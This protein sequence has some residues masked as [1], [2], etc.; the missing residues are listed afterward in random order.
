MELT[1]GEISYVARL[2]DLDTKRRGRPC[3]RLGYDTSSFAVLQLDP[4]R[5]LHKLS[6]GWGAST[7]QRPCVNSRWGAADSRFIEVDAAALLCAIRKDGD[8]AG[9]SAAMLTGFRS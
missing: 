8:V 3:P 6:A 7:W 5:L 1:A 4:I 9:R 2:Q